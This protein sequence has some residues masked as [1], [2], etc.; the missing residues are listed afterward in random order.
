MNDAEPLRIRIA[1][2]GTLPKES[3]LLLDQ[4]R[5]IDNRRLVKGPLLRL[6]ASAMKRV[7]A[8]LLEVLGVGN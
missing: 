4:M 3:D 2:V 5:A 7:G 1:A 8:A 6:P